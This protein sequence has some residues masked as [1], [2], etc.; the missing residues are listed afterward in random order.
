MFGISK[1][2]GG[3][4]SLSLNTDE[5][6]ATLASGINTMTG[7]GRKSQRKTIWLPVFRYFTTN[8]QPNA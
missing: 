3:L 1:G 7:N 5:F 4:T 6:S 2:F 8:N